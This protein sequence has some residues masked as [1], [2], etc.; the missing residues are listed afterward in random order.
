MLDRGTA[1]TIVHKPDQVLDGRCVSFEDGLYRAVV[2]VRDPAGEAALS[3]A[4]KHGVAEADSLHTAM[5]YDAAPD[6]AAYSRLVEFRELLRRRRMVRAYEPEPIPRDAVERI[7]ATVRR[8]PSAGFSQG[9]RLIV[10]TE[11]ATN[12]RRLRRR[13]VGRRRP[14]ALD[15]RRAGPDRRLRPRAGLPRPLHATGQAA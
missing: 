10:V 13:V 8:A 2:P 5:G 9:Q 7:V 4:L 12:C 15:L 1:R 3:R 14:R 11:P 6:H